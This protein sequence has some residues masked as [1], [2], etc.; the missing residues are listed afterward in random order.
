M[1]NFHRFRLFHNI[2]VPEGSSPRF[3]A[4]WAFCGIAIA[5]GDASEGHGQKRPD[6]E[7]EQGWNLRMR[8]FDATSL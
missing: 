5:R 4:G 2:P 6:P 8:V 3:H 7:W 1:T